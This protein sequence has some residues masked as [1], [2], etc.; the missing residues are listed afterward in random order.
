M[1]DVVAEDI[2]PLDDATAVLIWVLMILTMIKTSAIVARSTWFTAKHVLRHMA[3]LSQEAREIVQTFWALIATLLYWLSLAE[4]SLGGL[5][6]SG[7]LAWWL[8]VLRV[9]TVALLV[10]GQ[11]TDCMAIS[12]QQ[13]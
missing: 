13:D 2:L 3:A 4:A 8:M 9:F 5:E 7:D 1:A 12:M 10:N 11:S 6:W